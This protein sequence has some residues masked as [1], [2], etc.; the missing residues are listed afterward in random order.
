M[1]RKEKVVGSQLYLLIATVSFIK[2]QIVLIKNHGA[3]LQRSRSLHN[4]S[5]VDKCTKMCIFVPF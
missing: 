3:A 1:K 2:L 5:K 4:I